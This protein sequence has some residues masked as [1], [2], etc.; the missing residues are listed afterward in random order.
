MKRISIFMPP[1]FCILAI[2][3]LQCKHFEKV[4]TGDTASDEAAIRKADSAWSVATGSKQ[5]NDFMSY[6]AEDGIIE[7]PNAPVAKGKD[8]VQKLMSSF[9]SIPGFS[10][11]WQATKVEAAGSG[12]MGYSIGAYELNVNDAQGKPMTDHGKYTTIWKKQADGNW[13]VTVDMFNS[14]LPAQ[15]PPQK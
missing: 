11:K 14:D 3:S 4:A 10:V 15:P 13:K 7:A 2:L 1:C 8:D 6:M 9:F 5:I 12:D